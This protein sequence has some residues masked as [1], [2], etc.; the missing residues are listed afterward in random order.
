MSMTFFMRLCY[1][2]AVSTESLLPRLRVELQRV[3]VPEKALKMQR[4]MKSEMPYLGVAA[5]ELRIACKAVFASLTFADAR[6][7]RDAVTTIWENARHREEWYAA[8]E[9]SGHR[10]ARA[11]QTFEALPLYERMIVEGAWWDIVD[12]V[13]TQRLGQLLRKEARMRDVMLAWS[14]DEHMWKRRA[15]IISQLQ[16]KEATDLELLY[17]C[18]EPS[19]SS[20]EFFLR[21]AIGWALR[22]LARTNPEEV[23]RYVREHESLLS[24]LSKREALKHL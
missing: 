10:A 16:L 15:S 19:L 13:A 21:K 20:R 17:A 22:Q 6:Q 23:R 12:A 18:I 14:T 7:W 24:P 2:G 11:F 3:A 4:Y 1:R 8:I 9:L 5:P